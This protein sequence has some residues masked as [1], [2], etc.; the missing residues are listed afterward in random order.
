MRENAI[1]AKGK[2]YLYVWCWDVCG[3]KWKI[4]SKF[5]TYIYQENRMTSCK[6]NK[7]NPLSPTPQLGYLE[8]IFQQVVS[9]AQHF[10]TSALMRLLK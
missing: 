5:T 6:L 4:S 8:G 9:L 3:S 2:Q 7:L 1:S 10:C